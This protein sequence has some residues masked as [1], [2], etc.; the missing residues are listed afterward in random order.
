MLR[1][2][3]PSRVAAVG[4]TNQRETIVVWERATGRPIANAIVWQDTRTAGRCAE[5]V[6]AGSEPHVRERTGL[7]I[8]PYFSAT[9]LAWLLDNVP[10]ARARAE[11]GELAAGTIE[12]WLAWK[13]TGGADG[14]SHISDVTNASRTLLLD[15]RDARVVGRAARALRRP[16]LRA[17]CASFPPGSRVAS[18]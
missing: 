16:S 1:E 13:L 18:G 17:P 4:I 8:Q 12:S 6:A 14:G 2:V 15:T 11:A 9:K 5:L 7:P 3:E 10:A